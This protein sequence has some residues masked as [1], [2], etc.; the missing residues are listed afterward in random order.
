MIKLI[1][2]ANLYANGRE[3]ALKIVFFG[4][5]GAGKGSALSYLHR[6]LR[7]ETRGPIITANTLADAAQKAVAAAKAA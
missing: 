4:P 1:T 6:A 3:L 5:A 2:V 7:P